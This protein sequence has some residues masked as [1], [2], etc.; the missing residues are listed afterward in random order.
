VDVQA[1]PSFDAVA[2]V[3]SQRRSI[4]RY[5][6]RRVP[7]ETIEEL[8][9]LAVCAPSA[10][11]RQPW[12][13]TVLAPFHAERLATSM[14]SKLR[15]DR[16]QD[17]DPVDAI[18]DDA[19]R[20]RSR[21][22]EAPVV[23]LVCLT[24]E[25]MDTYPDRARQDAEHQMAVQSVAMAVQNLLLAAHARGLGACWM[26]APLFCPDVVRMTVGLPLDWEPQ[27]LLTLGYPQNAGKPRSRR[28]VDEV[29]RFL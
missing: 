14:A 28:P 2:D 22:I 17:G 23:I 26:C 27:A 18:D 19:E 21:I 15:R 20:S 4:R 16:L 8:L 6:R 1:V 11:N 5:A 24:L 13:F 29:A 10:H 9:R 25:D 12:R 3:I 7:R